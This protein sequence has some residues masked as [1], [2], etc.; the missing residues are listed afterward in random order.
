MYFSSS[1]VVFKLYL[2]L[3]RVYISNLRHASQG[4]TYDMD[5]SR[6]FTVQF[7]LDISFAKT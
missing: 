4:S 7:R 2:L 3:K 5:I 1:R 6:A